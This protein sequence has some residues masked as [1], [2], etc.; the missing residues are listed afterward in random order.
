LVREAFVKQLGCRLIGSFTV[1]EVPGNFHVSNHAYFNH[2][3]QVKM[4]GHAPADLDMSHTI[5]KLYF[6]QEHH[7]PRLK[8]LHP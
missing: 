5:H 3:M 4:E 6:G 1:K 7:L 2:Y 8:R